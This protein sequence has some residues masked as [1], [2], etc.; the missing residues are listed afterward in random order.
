MKCLGGGSDVPDML[1]DYSPG[2]PWSGD[3]VPSP[4]F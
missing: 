3:G 4:N 2:I 1:G